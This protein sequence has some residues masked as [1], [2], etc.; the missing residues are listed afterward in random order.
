M[1]DGVFQTATFKSKNSCVVNSKS[2]LLNGFPIAIGRKTLIRY[3]PHCFR[4][5]WDFFLFLIC[6]GNI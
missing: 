5:S 2:S 1:N 6:P 4:E 3:V